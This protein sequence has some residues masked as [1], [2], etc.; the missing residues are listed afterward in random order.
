VASKFDGPNTK[1]VFFTNKSY[2]PSN[3]PSGLKKLREKELEDLRGN[4]QGERKRFERIYD[5]D[6][7]NDLGD[8]DA[9]FNSARPVLGGPQHPY[10][11]RCRTGRGPTKTDP[12]SEKRSNYVYVPRDEEFSEIKG[13]AFGAKTVRSVLK[14]I[15][16][17]LETAL[18][19]AHLGFP[20]FTRIDTLYNEGVPIPTDKGIFKAMI[21]RLIKMIEEGEE[22]LLLFEPPEIINRDKFAWF[23]DEEFG[24]QTL[25]GLNPYSIQL[26]TEWPL[27]SK[28]DPK[29]YGTPESS[30]T[31]EIVEREMKGLLKLEEALAQKK[32]FIIDY[33]DL[34]LP[35]VQKVRSLEG[36]T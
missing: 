23:R 19:D 4:G 24:R 9:G 32:L 14:A 7:Y 22:S 1:R 21:P 25:A 20:H 17:S 15:I 30:I 10:P 27:K 33:H 5:Y 28:L 8:P 26:V 6:V 36:T 13:L 12:S 29:V 2:L 35:L 3:T 31:K 34:F 11:R 18:V 16:P